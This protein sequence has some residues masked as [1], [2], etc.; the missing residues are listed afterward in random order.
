MVWGS[1]IGG[2]ICLGHSIRP[3]AMAEGSHGYV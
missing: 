3:V 2:T 1:D